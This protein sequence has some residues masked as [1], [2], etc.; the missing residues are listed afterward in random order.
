MRVLRA[1]CD[2]GCN[3]VVAVLFLACGTV[4]QARGVT[5]W[6]DTDPSIG[7][8][9]HEVDDGFALILAFHSPEIRIAGIS[10]TYGNA[11]LANTTR[12]AQDL[13][14]RFD[15]KKCKVYPG[16]QSRGELGRG[17]E[18]TRALA[19]A[20]RKQHLIYIGLG[21]LTNLATFLRLHPELEQRID[22]V[23]MVGGQTSDAPIRIGK[24]GRLSIHDANVFKDADAAAEVLKS[25]C[26]ISLA[27]IETSIRLQIT[28]TD[29]QTI[30]AT[31]SGE[32]LYR[33][34]RLWSWFWRHVVGQEGGP[35]FDVL[36]ILAV[37]RPGLVSSEE[38]YAFVRGNRR[39]TI[40]ETRKN[41]G[42]TIKIYSVF[43]P[44]ALRFLRERL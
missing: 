19:T 15:R 18:A 34:S 32:F 39:M 29:L 6:I 12:I 9:F 21:P 35:V 17:T 16:A 10:T 11:S 4:S 44:S 37:I 1:K 31:T 30:R 36:P 24:N 8:P 23:I 14:T 13:V 41:G 42:R 5:V 20:A 22:G 3:L 25:K 26:P 38:H 33:R 2:N 7:L 28:P 27:P 43:A 40:E